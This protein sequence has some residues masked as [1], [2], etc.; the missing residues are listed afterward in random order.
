MLKKTLRER[1]GIQLIKAFAWSNA[2][3]SFFLESWYRDFES[4]PKA[5]MY[6]HDFCVCDEHCRTGLL[7]SM[8]SHQLSLRIKISE[9]RMAKGQKNS[10]VKKRKKK[11]REE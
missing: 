1:E 6:V 8:E 3:D 5:W 7:P 11:R 2:Q 10:S 4:T 9:I